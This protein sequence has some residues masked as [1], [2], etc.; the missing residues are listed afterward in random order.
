M[1]PVL[2]WRRPGLPADWMPVLERHP[3]E[4]AALP[5]Y[6]WLDLAGR[7]RHVQERDLEFRE[8]SP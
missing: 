5:G 6:V 7:P 2:A 4:I 1:P 8:E 3:D